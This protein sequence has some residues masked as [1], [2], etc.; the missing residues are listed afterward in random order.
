MPFF[1]WMPM[2]LFSSMCHV[3]EDDTRE[4]IAAMS[5]ACG[6]AERSEDRGEAER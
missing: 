4:M 5:N 6:D 3:I 1:F 2:I